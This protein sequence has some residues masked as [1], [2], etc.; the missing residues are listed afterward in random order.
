M[1]IATTSVSRQQ[2]YVTVFF[3]THDEWKSSKSG[4]AVSN[5]DQYNKKSRWHV[6]KKKEVQR[7]LVSERKAGTRSRWPHD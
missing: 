5:V 1:M 6:Q 7:A 2:S 3:V 4:R